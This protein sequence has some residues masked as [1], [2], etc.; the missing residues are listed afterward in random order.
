MGKKKNDI[1]QSTKSVSTNKDSKKVLSLSKLSDMIDDLSEETKITI[2]HD[3]EQN[4]IST[5]ILILD[6]LLSKSILNGGV[7]NDRITVFAGEPQTGKSY[8]LYN[9]ARNAQK[10][11]YYVIFIDTEHS[12]SKQTLGTFGLKTDRESLKLIVSNKVED[13][14]VWMTKMLNDLKNKKN[15]GMEIPKI[16]FFIDSIGQLAS[17]KEMND[18][19]KGE[20]KVDMSRA[21]AI[22]QFF[23]IINADLGYLRIPLIATNHVYADT[24]SFFPVPVMSGGK[25]TEYSASTIVFLSTAKLK[26]GREDEMDLNASGVVITA[27]AKKNRIAKP[28]KVKFELDHTYGI[29][30]YKGLDFFCTPENFSTVGIAKGKPVTNPDETIGIEPGGTRWY[31]RHL[32]KSFFY[33]QLFTPEVFTQ[34][35][36][37]VLHPIIYKYFDYASFDE[38]QQFLV[39]MDE[40]YNDEPIIDDDFDSIDNSELFS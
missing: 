15:D 25:G 1:T 2:E 33:K 38:Q 29:N 37:D 10:E 3:D 6:A 39:K 16:I 28:K 8:I 22:K 7:A 27:Q 40:D 35:I 19:L 11:G 24:S 36:L 4:F 26:T 13:L 18:A 21:K 20:I 12:V 34:D 30:K 32:D 14:K 9:I 17:D 23:R 31:V 5:S